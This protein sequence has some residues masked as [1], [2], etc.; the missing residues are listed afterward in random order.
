MAMRMPTSGRRM[1]TA[2]KGQQK[3]PQSAKV[4]ERSNLILKNRKMMST[5]RSDLSL[6]SGAP[7]AV[8]TTYVQGASATLAD[9]PDLA[10]VLPNQFNELFRQKLGECCVLCNFSDGPQSGSAGTK[11]RYLQEIGEFLGKPRYFQ[12]C[13]SQTFD[14][15]FEMIKGNL[16]RALPPVPPISKSVLLGDDIKDSWVDGAWPHLSLVYDVF[17]AFLESPQLTPAQHLKRFDNTFLVQFLGLFNSMDARERDCV[18]RVLHTLY[19]RFN[20]LRSKLRQI[21]Q[22]ILFTFIYEEKY[23]NGVNELLDFYE[24]I[25]SGFGVPIKPENIRFLFETLMPLHAAEFLHVFHENLVA[26]IA[27][28]I[29]KDPSLSPSI[30]RKLLS[31]WPSSTQKGRLFITEIGQ[32]VDGMSEEQFKEIAEELFVV[33]SRLIEGPNFQLCEAAVC[34]WKS[35]VFVTATA[36]FATITYPIILPGVYRCGVSHWHAAIKNL[37]VSILRI[38]M[39]IAPEIYDQVMKG[40]PEI[41]QHMSRRL[42]AEKGAWFEVAKQA[43][44]FD[45]DVGIVHLPRSIDELFAPPAPVAQLGG[46]G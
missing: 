24:S 2:P 1:M 25:V 27:D 34:L 17:Q 33:L 31:Y 20:Q 13:D 26:C 14:R 28:Y 23:F 35:D 38:C 21:L 32:L 18:K 41:E 4:V 12:L 22:Q 3:G 37:A 7:K 19:L 11:S 29:D 44:G 5:P 42:E 8:M 36:Q 9:L 43:E 15:L 45:P 46:A 10:S 40:L 6:S 39:Q 16:I 30:L